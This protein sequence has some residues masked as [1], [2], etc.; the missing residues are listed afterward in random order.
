LNWGRALL[1]AAREI[2][3]SIGRLIRWVVVALLM[4]LIIIWIIML[5]VAIVVSMSQCIAG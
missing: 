3:Y 2:L 5:L 1:W 4:R